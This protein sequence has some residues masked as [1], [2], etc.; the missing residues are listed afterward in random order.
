[1]VNWDLPDKE[2][3]SYVHRIGRTGRAGRDGKAVS[4]VGLDDKGILKRIEMLIGMQIEEAD[5]PARTKGRD[6]VEHKIDWDEL[7]D[8]YGNVHIRMSA[9]ADIGLTPYKLHRLVQKGSGLS[10]HAIGDLKIEAKE[11]S[12][13][14]PK[15]T[16]LR[17]RNGV[18]NFFKG[19]KRQV[20]V[21]FIDKETTVR[22]A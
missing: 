3:E 16:A 22:S 14:V 17:A 18:R 20:T 8:K 15:D 13:A 9:G 19:K 6:K 7:A 21:E 2:P 10:D 1:M 5:V 11:A 4:F 12:F